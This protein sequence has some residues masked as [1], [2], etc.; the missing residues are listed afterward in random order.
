MDGRGGADGG[1]RRGRV[2]G[3][4]GVG[5]G[6]GSACKGAGAMGGAHAGVSGGRAG[7]KKPTETLARTCGQEFCVCWFGGPPFL[8]QVERKV[9]T[10]CG[11]REWT[12]G[13]FVLHPS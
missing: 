7:G 8:G 6:P 13:F 5:S 12:L 1:G 10:I 2:A 3:G 4:R 9:A 11:S